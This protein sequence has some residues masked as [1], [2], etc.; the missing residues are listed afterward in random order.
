[1]QSHNP[2]YLF[3]PACAR[4]R[5]N[6]VHA[7]LCPFPF[8]PYFP[9]NTPSGNSFQP[10]S[11]QLVPLLIS[12]ILPRKHTTNGNT[13]THESS[14]GVGPDDLTDHALKPAFKTPLNVSFFYLRLQPPGEAALLLLGC[15]ISIINKTL[16]VWPVGAPDHH[17]VRAPDE[18]YSSPDSAVEY[19]KQASRAQSGSDS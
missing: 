5:F 6:H 12:T 17:I 16:Y 9:E 14:Q 11:Y 1:M 3:A 15:Q 7:S 10:Y 13:S 19:T 8:Q 4:S 2:V 18:S